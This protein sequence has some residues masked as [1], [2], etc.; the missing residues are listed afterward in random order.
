MYSLIVADSADDI[1]RYCQSLGIALSDY[2]LSEVVA[3][4]GPHMA[5][6]RSDPRYRAPKRP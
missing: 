6:S 1:K 5:M 2:K 3:S 4:L